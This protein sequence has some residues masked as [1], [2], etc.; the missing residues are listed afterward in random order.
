MR[1]ARWIFGV[2]SV[3]GILVIAPLYFA[4]GVIAANDPPAI[5]HPE[6]FYGFVGV[7]LAWQFLYG[8]IA[9]DPARFRPIMPIGAAGKISF[10]VACTALY[11]GGRLGATTFYSSLIDLLLALLFLV[12]WAKLASGKPGTDA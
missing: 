4:E 2:A 11:F 12:A 5:T 8:L 9:T 1:T 10:T 7:T 6:F 3:W